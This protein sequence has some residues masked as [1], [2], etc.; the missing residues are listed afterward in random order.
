MSLSL[1]RD[2]LLRTLDILVLLNVIFCEFSGVV[3]EADLL[4]DTLDI[5]FIVF[6]DVSGLASTLAG[7]SMYGVLDPNK[8][9]DLVF[10]ASVCG[11]S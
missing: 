8:L 2:L 10:L 11:V 4:V 1:I 3:M 5:E 9:V 6:L 7:L